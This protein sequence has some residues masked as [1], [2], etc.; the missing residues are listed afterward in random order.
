MG[1]HLHLF[2]FNA[3]RSRS[4]VKIREFYEYFESYEPDLV[5]IQE[6]NVASALQVFSDRFQVYINLEQNSQDG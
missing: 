6:I 4:I 1:G 3:F 5:F 2:N